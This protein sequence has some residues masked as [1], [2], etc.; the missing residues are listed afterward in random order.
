MTNFKPNGFSLTA[1]QPVIWSICGYFN[2][3]H[4]VT[5]AKKIAEKNHPDV[6][7]IIEPVFISE[8]KHS[9]QRMGLRDFWTKPA[10]KTKTLEELK[11][12]FKH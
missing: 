10:P 5:E 1:M 11:K 8:K 7:F 12:Y 6:K 4:A 9:H 2:T 3:K